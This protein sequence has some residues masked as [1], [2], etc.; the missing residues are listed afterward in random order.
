M[1]AIDQ[2]YFQ[3]EQEAFEYLESVRWPDGP[4]CPHCGVVNHAYA[5]ARVG[6]YRCADKGCRKDFTVRVGTVFEDSPIKLHKWLLAAY[7]VCA[8]KKGI[9]S[10]QLQ[11]M[12]GV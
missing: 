2:I 1:C 10:L 9:S 6:R 5:C 11:R 8:S 4:V 7:L 3:D 12:L